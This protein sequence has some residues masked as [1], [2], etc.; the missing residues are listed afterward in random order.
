MATSVNADCLTDPDFLEAYQAGKGT[1]SWGPYEPKWRTYVCCWA[2]RRGAQLQGDFVECGVN[3]GGMSLA[4]AKLLRFERLAPRKFY[5]FDTFHGPVPQQILP[6]EEELRRAYA[7][8]YYSECYDAVRYAFR[9]YPNVEL[10]RGPV[11]D[12]LHEHNIESVAYLSIDMNF[13]MPELAAAEHFWDR[14]VSGAS[15]VLD[16]YAFPGH[17]EQRS[18]FDA[19]ARRRNVPLL[20]LPTGQGLIQK[21]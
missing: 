4:V 14:L 13:A 17:D 18:G 15:I 8:G 10:V 21:P 12:T 7:A 16:D 2:A 1:G 19:F 9:E 5:L 3:R 6:G 11:P 20:T